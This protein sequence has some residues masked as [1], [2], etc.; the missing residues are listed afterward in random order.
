VNIGRPTRIHEIEP[1]SIPMP[2]TVP[3]EP[4][5]AL[6]VESPTPAEPPA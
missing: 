1:V 3:V 5:P 4:S 6:P 2:V